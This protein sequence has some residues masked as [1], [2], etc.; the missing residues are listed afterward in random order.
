MRDLVREMRTKVRLS[1]PSLTSIGPDLPLCKKDQSY[2]E[3]AVKIEL[4]ERRMEAVKK[5]ADA[6]SELESELVKSKKQERAYEDA[7]EL[8]QTDLDTMEQE[9]NKLK[10]SASVADK[11]G[12]SRLL[13]SS[14]SLLTHGE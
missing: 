14:L 12:L 11:L 4:M 13:A 6:I 8:L 3:S 7:I 9:N 5:Q 2:Q 10:Q 1:L